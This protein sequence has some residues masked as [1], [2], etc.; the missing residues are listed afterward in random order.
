MRVGDT[1]AL[2]A[3]FSESDKY[4]ARARRALERPETIWVP[5][6]VMAEV[7][8]L[9][10]RRQGRAAAQA[11]GEFL[12]GHPSTELQPSDAAITT[13]AWGEYMAAEGGLSWP[14]CIVVA[15]CRE[16]EADPLTF[17]RG[18]LRALRR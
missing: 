17:D 7:L 13:S 11:V 3:F 4:H 2:Y 15:A 6:E 12:W 1:S 5:A 10:E 8:W 18:I 16:L 14:D 9:T